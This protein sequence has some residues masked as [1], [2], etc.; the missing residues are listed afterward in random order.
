MIT[1]EYISGFF[2][3]DGSVCLT[4]QGKGQIKTTQ[5]S[6][7]NNELVI[8]KKIKSFIFENIGVNG[9]ISKKSARKETH[10]DSYDLTYTYRSAIE[11]LKRLDVNHPKKRHRKNVLLRAHKLLPKNGKFKAGIEE[12]W[13]KIINE[14]K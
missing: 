12:K 3:A 10:S 14:Y 8:L 4:R 5:L 13:Q 11:V 1:W 2:D 6:F 9:S 7:H